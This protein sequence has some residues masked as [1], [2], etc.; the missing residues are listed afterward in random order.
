MIEVVIDTREQ[1]PWHFPPEYAE[2]SRGKLDA[3][4]YALLGDDYFAVERKSLDDFVSTV[5]SGWERFQRELTRMDGMFY[6]C[7]VVIVESTMSEIIN[8]RYSSPK[9]KPAFV[10]KR[11]SVLTMQRVSIL[12][13][14]N[15]ATAAGMCL[16]LLRERR[17]FL[18]E[19]L[20]E[21]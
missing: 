3:G 11:I 7:K 9:V 14:A 12:F 10:L 1:T 19:D 17:N 6:P 8:H 13:A 16:S 4:D 20:N 2:V 18:K 15:R 21:T 5:A